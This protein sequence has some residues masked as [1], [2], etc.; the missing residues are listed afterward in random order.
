MLNEY[1]IRQDYCYTCMALFK[2]NLPCLTESEVMLSPSGEVLVCPGEQLAFVCSTNKLFIEW[3]ITIFQSGQSISQA[4]LVSS[5]SP[6]ETLV[7]NM[8]AFHI[9]RNEF[10]PLTY[11]LIVANITADLNGT[12]VNCTDVGDSFADT[13]T[14]LAVLKIG[15]QSNPQKSL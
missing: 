14:S 8:K 4:R 11:T 2:L 5:V 6:I 7:V 1:K 3:N 10:T 12:R 15:R 9:I 13:S